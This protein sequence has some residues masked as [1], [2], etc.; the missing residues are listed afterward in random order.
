MINSCHANPNGPS[1]LHRAQ[2]GGVGASARLVLLAAAG[3]LLAVAAAGPA[4]AESDSP[5]DRDKTSGTVVVTGGTLRITA[6][7]DAG[8]LGKRGHTTS[9]GTVKG[10]L[11]QVRVTDTRGA[12]P[13]SGWVASAISSPLNGPG[14]AVIPASAVGYVVGEID[15]EG[16]ATYRAQNPSDLSDL[17]PVVKATNVAGNNTATWSP[18]ITVDVPGGAR[19]GTYAVT[20]THSVI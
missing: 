1:I 10:S 9:S 17:V 18:T 5:S 14:K 11:G 2:L 19:A 3:S 16:T 6:P 20:V 4:S 12:A 7:G 13:G 8:V 15:R